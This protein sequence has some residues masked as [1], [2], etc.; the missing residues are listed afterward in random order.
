VEI[1]SKPIL[2]IGDDLISDLQPILVTITLRRQEHNG[3]IGIQFSPL[4]RLVSVDTILRRDALEEVGRVVEWVG[5]ALSLLSLE[6][7]ASLASRTLGGLLDVDDL[8]LLLDELSLLLDDLP[9]L[10][11]NLS[12]LLHKLADLPALAQRRDLGADTLLASSNHRRWNLLVDGLLLDDDLSS[13]E[14]SSSSTLDDNWTSINVADLRTLA[15]VS[16]WNGDDLGLDD[17]G[18]TSDDP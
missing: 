8:R 5:D 4:D 7:V 12:W 17:T 16:R 14:V 10:A 13:L 15:S 9:S 6:V 1:I 11:H 18:T 2:A 3:S